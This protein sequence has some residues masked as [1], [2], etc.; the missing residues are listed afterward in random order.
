MLKLLADE[1]V[2]PRVV[3]VLRKEKFDILSIVEKKL[4]GASDERI[5]KLARRQR[6]IIL[7]HDKD[8]GNLVHRPDQKHGGV[9][10]LRLR[11]Q[12]PTN[13]IRNL[14]PFLRKI[15]SEKVKNRLVIF[16]EGKIRII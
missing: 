7:T 4:S 9:I 14:T 8:F 13:V 1:N 3:E 15:K 12:S 5:L 11:N 10:L 16:Q 2:A 6:R